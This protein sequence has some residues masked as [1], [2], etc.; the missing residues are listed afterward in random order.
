MYRDHAADDNALLSV[1][2]GCR[3]N[4]IF[5]YHFD[6]ETLTIHITADPDDHQTKLPVLTDLADGK[7]A[8]ITGF[9]HP[10]FYCMT[11]EK[12]IQFSKSVL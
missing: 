3:K 8:D 6:T 1:N 5:F 10:D 2:T 4:C 7:P 12:L 11:G 9:F